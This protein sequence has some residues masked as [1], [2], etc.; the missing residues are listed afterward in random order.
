MKATGYECLSEFEL[1][2]NRW[3]SAEFLQSS[4]WRS[5]F[6]GFEPAR[7][8][9]RSRA[10]RGSLAPP[11]VWRK[12][13]SDCQPTMSVLDLQT[14]LRSRQRSRQSGSKAWHA[15]G[16]RIQHFIH[17]S[18]K[19]ETRNKNLSSSSE[20]A[21][22]LMNKENLLRFASLKVSKEFKA[23][24]DGR[25]KSDPEGH[26]ETTK[27][28]LCSGVW[29]QTQHLCENDPA[30]CLQH[31]LLP[32]NNDSLI[33]LRTEFKNRQWLCFLCHIFKVMP[34]TLNFWKQNFARLFLLRQH[35]LWFSLNLQVQRGVT[36]SPK[37]KSVRDQIQ[38]AYSFTYLCY[39]LKTQWN[40]IC[41]PVK[42]QR[43]AGVCS[44]FQFFKCR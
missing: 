39:I 29:E 18:S 13:A 27:L 24:K 22:K 10:H 11:S 17:W 35:H 40:K 36:K 28:P 9:S 2:M 44:D 41:F 25:F 7:S 38:P 43:P 6:S 1:A 42:L 19:S 4:S 16:L 34:Q 20:S 33:T 32:G 30:V 15:P 37:W 8:W 14:D 31:S 12:T 21:R 5:S 23:S 26:T 3:M